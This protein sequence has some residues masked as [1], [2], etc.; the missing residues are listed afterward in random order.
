MRRT[1]VLKHQISILNSAL[2]KAM[3]SDEKRDFTRR[4]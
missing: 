2:S 4:C 1:E 3:F